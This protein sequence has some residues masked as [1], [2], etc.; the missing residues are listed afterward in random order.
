[1]TGSARPTELDPE[2]IE[3]A[4]SKILPAVVEWDRTGG[5]NSTEEEIANDLREEI[6]I[7]RDGYEFCRELEKH[8]HWD[9]DR[10]LV[11]ILDSAD[12]S[13]ALREMEKRWVAA[14]Q[15]FPG[16]LIGNQITWEGNTAEI[17]ALHADGKYTVFVPALGHVK[18]GLGTHGIIIPWERVDGKVNMLGLTITGPLL[19]AIA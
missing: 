4:L 13:G 19:E 16:Q 14:Y 15:V 18:S 5:G 8:K 3:M 12:M 17:T 6:G 10:E 11:D 9:C 1:M 7:H 2:V